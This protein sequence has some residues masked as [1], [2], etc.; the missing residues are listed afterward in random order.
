MINKI[1]EHFSYSDSTENLFLFYQRVSELLFDYSPDSYKVSIHNSHS[2]CIE[3]Y[4]LF[5]YL[6]EDGSSL[7]FYEQYIPDILAELIHSLRKDCIAKRLLGLRYNKYVELLEQCKNVK[8]SA[9]EIKLFKST[10][11]NLRNQFSNKKYYNAI[12]DKLVSLLHEKKSQQHLID[13]ADSFLCELI[14][15]GYSKQHIYN[16]MIAFFRDTCIDDV[17]TAFSQLLKMFN[18]KNQEWEIITFANEKLYTYYCDELSEVIQSD[19]IRISNV[20]PQELEEIIQKSPAFEWLKYR[21]ENLKSANYPVSL[22]K[23][24]INDS[25]PYSAYASLERFLDAVNEMVTLFDNEIKVGYPSIA[26]LNYQYKKTIKIQRSMEK[27]PRL[28]HDENYAART[29]TVLKKMHMSTKMFHTLLKTAEFHSD[30][31]N[32]TTND[33]Y[34]LVIL[35]TALEALFVDNSDNAHKSKRVLE[36]LIAIIQRTYVTKSLKYLQFDLIRHLKMSAPALI[37]KYHLDNLKSFIDV[38]FSP[39]ETEAVK[40]I[41][42]AIEKNLLLRTRIF[43]ITDSCCKTNE[44]ILKWLENHQQKIEWQIKR[45]YRTRNIIVHTGRT[46]PYTADLVENLHNYVDFIINFI[47]CKSWNGET[48]ADINSLIAE[49]EMDNELHY[50]ILKNSKKEE[51]VE[52]TYTSLFGPSKN[53]V[54]YYSDFN[55]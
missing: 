24:T 22:I 41:S 53:I 16:V 39:S 43:Y 27:R 32:K 54:D 6:E 37:E 33:N 14:L 31:L 35:W 42:C 3:A 51:T 30:A 5:R 25:D 2:L 34:T 44:R 23:A 47:I 26:C 40:E 1:P 52:D 48:I 12:C 20:A 49:V 13:L 36:G 4:E 28:L 18:F 10:I 38:L 21:L 8:G 17:D 11:Y 55:I 46:V 29:A 19:A 15:L 9:S 7:R 45:I 50:Q